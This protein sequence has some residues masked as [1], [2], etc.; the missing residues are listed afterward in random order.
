MNGT[1]VTDILRKIVER[2]GANEEIQKHD[3]YLLSACNDII[4]CAVAGAGKKY[5]KTQ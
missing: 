2:T 3:V 5:S 4:T 1:I